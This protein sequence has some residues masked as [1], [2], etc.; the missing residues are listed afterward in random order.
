MARQRCS[1]SAGSAARSRLRRFMSVS[2]TP[3]LIAFTRMLLPGILDR[4]DARHRHDRALGCRV[5]DV[6]ADIGEGTHRGIVDDRPAARP[7]QGRD[8]VLAAEED[9]LEVDA[10]DTVEQL[11][12]NVGR[13][14]HGLLDTRIVEDRV[15]AAESCLRGRQQGLDVRLARNV[16]MPIDEAP[17]DGARP[18]GR[19]YRPRRRRYLPR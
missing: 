10:D 16:A 15:E 12:R 19:A 8:G 1:I 18:R 9:A 5:G 13:G 17:T 6:A 11:L 2:I 4:K 7:Q 14:R 3:G